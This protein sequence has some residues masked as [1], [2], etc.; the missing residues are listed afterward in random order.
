MSDIRVLVIDDS[1]EMRDFVIEYVLEP[2]G[3]TVIVAT[4]GAEGLRLALKETVDLI[5]LDLEMPR[6]NGFEVLDGLRAR[7]SQV[8]VILMTSHGSESIAVEVFHKGVRDYVI[9]PFTVE[10]MLGAI[11][12]ALTAVRLQR[13]KET[14]TTRLVQAKR[15]LEQR[16]R[17]FDTLYHVGK[18]VTSPITLDPTRVTY[19]WA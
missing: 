13:E 9:K 11:E 4:D 8:P 7:R 15:Q 19:T 2:N 3:Y 18:S 10:Q 16:L 6:M 17:E 14:L 1:R 5:L 12:Q